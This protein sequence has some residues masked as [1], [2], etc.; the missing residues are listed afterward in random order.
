M[1][2][3]FNWEGR[4]TVKNFLK[5]IIPLAALGT[6][7]VWY[8]GPLYV[9][10]SALQARFLPCQQP[11]AYSLGTFDARFG[12]SQDTF[13]RDI[14]AAEAIWE[15]PVGRQLFS[16]N[17][18]GALKVNLIYDYRQAATVKLRALGYAVEESQSSYD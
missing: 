9:I 17:P 18:S 8:R 14:A 2:F 16:Y 12:I 13:L 7:L 5:T 3:Y 4:E 1:L 15:V 6:A 10:W 11:I